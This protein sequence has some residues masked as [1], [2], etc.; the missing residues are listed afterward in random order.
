[1][2]SSKVFCLV[3]WIEDDLYG[4]IPLKDAE[5][6]GKVKSGKLASFKWR[7]R[8]KKKQRYYEALVLKISGS[9]LKIHELIQT[10]LY[11]T[12]VY[13]F[14]ISIIDDKLMLNRFIDD[15]IDGLT[16][17]ES[18]MEQERVKEESVIDSTTP[19]KLMPMKRQKGKYKQ[20]RNRILH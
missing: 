15:L 11:Y 18:V 19:V 7:S 9:Y 10:C 20:G 16:T 4:V 8:N 6:V 3:R 1:M 13:L 14:Y 12:S 17:E 2:D 5:N